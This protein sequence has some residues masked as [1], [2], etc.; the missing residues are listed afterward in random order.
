MAYSDNI[1]PYEG[2]QEDL[3]NLLRDRLPPG[4]TVTPKPLRPKKYPVPDFI[5]ELSGPGN[6]RTTLLVEMKSRLEPKDVG[7]LAEQLQSYVRDF[8]GEAVALVNSG[9]LGLSTRERLKKAGIPYAD[10][11]GNVRIVSSRPALFIETQGA[12]RS[13]YRE[14]RQA[15]TL[16]GAKAGRI[17]RALCD[18]RPPFAVRKLAASAGVDPGY[19][20]RLLAF[21]DNEELIRRERI[22]AIRPRPWL[23]E[24]RKERCGPVIEVRWRQLIERWARDYTFLESNRAFPY[25]E[26]RGLSGLA[27]RLA[28]VGEQVAVTGSAAAAEVAPVAPTRLLEAYVASPEKVA[29]KLGLRPAESGANVLLIRPYDPIVF[30]RTAERKGILYVSLVQAAVDLLTGPGRS[31]AEGKALLDWMEKNESAWRS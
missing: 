17:V 14:P 31:P 9:F 29:E 1:D 4:W 25:L 27:S 12:A 15:R 18:A 7:S 11:T 21:L 13:P 28:A 23:G 8:G 26:P 5:I 24:T 16:K 30:E 22:P 6:E 19:V 3:L 20:S 2:F 10:A